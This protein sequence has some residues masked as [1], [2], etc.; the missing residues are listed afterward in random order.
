VWVGLLGPVGAHPGLHHD[1]E[2]VTEL[3]AAEPERADLWLRRGRLHRMSDHLAA[4]LSDLDHARELAPEMGEVALERGLTLGALDRDLEALEELDRFIR[5]R[6]DSSLAYAERARIRARLGRLGPAITDYSRSLDLNED[7]EIYILRGRLQE[8]NGRLDDAAAGYRVGLE[9]LNGAVVLRLALIRVETERGNYDVALALIDEQLAQAAAKT[10]WYLRRGDVLEAAGKPA[11]AEAARREAL[12]EA[13]RVL[14][15]HPSALKRF[16][17]ARALLSLNEWE[18]ARR[19]LVAVSEQSPRFKA[20]RDLLAELESREA[21]AVSDQ[22][23]S[24]EQREP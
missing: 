17:R 11:A 23:P 16:A 8:Q 24:D 9:R 2:Q 7:V 14:A 19:D 13:D 10:D 4:S 1:I 22:T 5:L 18:A 15:L 3:L 6:T 21:A 20:A 12:A